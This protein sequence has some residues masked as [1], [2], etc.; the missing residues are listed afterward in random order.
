[1]YILNTVKQLQS[2][3]YDIGLNKDQPISGIE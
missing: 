2:H 1:M 3:P